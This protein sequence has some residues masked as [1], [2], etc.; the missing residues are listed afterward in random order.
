MHYTVFYPTPLSEI[1]PDDDNLDVCVT[2]ADGQTC[3][4][5]FATPRNLLT[6]MEQQGRGYLEPGLP[7]LEA[8]YLK[9]GTAAA[10]PVNVYRV[11]RSALARSTAARRLPLSRTNWSSR[12]AVSVSPNS[13]AQRP[14][15]IARL[16]RI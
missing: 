8:G 14:F 11:S 12:R 5:V 15:S 6:R 2:F 10:V 16:T 13:A 9:T 7:E 3:T 4:F 1:D